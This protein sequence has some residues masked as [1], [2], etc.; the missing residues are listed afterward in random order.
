MSGKLCAR[1]QRFIKAFS[2]GPEGVDAVEAAVRA[3]YSPRF[4][5]E[6]A[7]QLLGDPEVRNHLEKRLS[8]RSDDPQ[9]TRRAVL[10]GLL[11]EAG[12]HS[13]NSSPANRLKAWE[14][15]CKLLGFFNESK[16]AALP[17]VV[18]DIRIDGQKLERRANG[19]PL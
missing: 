9:F 19:R 12:D 8:G 11:R 2:E 1:K 6:R 14:L 4:A 15:V 3:G 16:D 7:A 18:Y 17:S 10:Q 13:G 5:K